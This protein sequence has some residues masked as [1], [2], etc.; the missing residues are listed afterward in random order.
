MSETTKHP[1]FQEAVAFLR[2]K[3]TIMSSELMTRFSLGYNSAGRLVDQLENAGVI[4]QFEG[5][6]A[7]KVLIGAS[8]SPPVVKQEAAITAEEFYRKKIRDA[9]PE[10]GE[11]A[12][13]KISISAESGMRWAKE[14]SDYCLSVSS[15][16]K[17]VTEASDEEMAIAHLLSLVPSLKNPS[18]EIMSVVS[19]IMDLSWERITEQ[20][21]ADMRDIKKI[22]LEFCTRISNILSSPSKQDKTNT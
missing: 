1:N 18:I 8:L 15:P 5:A 13:S 19:E 9:Q 14:Y 22:K 7:R 4:G 12:L 20:P 6:K 17:E 3:Q 21:K 10:I 11:F 2:G 16:A